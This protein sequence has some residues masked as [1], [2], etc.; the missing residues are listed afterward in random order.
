MYVL[1]N[2]AGGQGAPLSEFANQWVAKYHDTHAVAHAFAVNLDVDGDH[3]ISSQDLIVLLT[4][5]DTNGMYI[6]LCHKIH[7]VE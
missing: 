3:F 1:F 2:A 6:V 7:N 4:R 5:Y